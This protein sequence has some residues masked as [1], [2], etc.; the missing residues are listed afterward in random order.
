MSPL[1]RI[2]TGALLAAA[3]LSGCAGGSASRDENPLTKMLFHVREHPEDRDFSV[4]FC[5][6][7]MSQKDSK[8]YIKPFIAGMLDVPESAGGEAFCGALI[9]AAIAGDLQDRDITVFSEDREGH[10]GAAVG[11]MLRALL[12]AHERLQ[13]EQVLNQPSP[14][15]GPLSSG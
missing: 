12:I 11:A 2:A 14:P 7:A 9:E 15:A 3:L 10:R 6:A 5:G 1:L 4:A 13:T 8:D